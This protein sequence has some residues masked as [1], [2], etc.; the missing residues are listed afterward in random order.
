MAFRAKMFSENVK[1]WLLPYM[2][3]LYVGNFFYVIENK[4]E[5]INPLLKRVEDTMDDLAKNDPDYWDNY[6]YLLFLKAFLLKLRRDTE[7]AITYFHEILSL[8]S[9]L[10]REVHII[11]QTCLEIALIHRL[12]GKTAETKRWISKTSK[13]SEYVTEFVVGWRCKYVMDHLEKVDYPYPIETRTHLPT[14]D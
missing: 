14:D 12:N 7:D 8:E 11:P 4:P 2:E 10:E 3:V 1:G 9:I 13:Y 6:A 5:Y